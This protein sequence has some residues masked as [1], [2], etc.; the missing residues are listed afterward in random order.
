MP[1]TFVG[2]LSFLAF[3]TPGLIHH[4]Q[5]RR[6]V[7]EASTSQLVET[8]TLVTVSLATNLLTLGLF[9]LI[10]I[11][12][13][14]HSP[15][16]RRLLTE[17]NGYIGSRAGY[18]LLWSVAFVVVSS[19]F[20]SLLGLFGDKLTGRL[21]RAVEFLAPSI[22]NTSA[23]YKVFE[24]CPTDARVYVGC[25]LRDGMYLGGYLAWYSTEV[26][27]TADRDLILGGGLTVKKGGKVE[28]SE[29]DRVVI[30]AREVERIY[31]TYVTRA[32]G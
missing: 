24:D 18:I 25:D 2:L 28:T 12:A 14:S 31:V 3:L 20:A 7:P 19:L 17:G 5:R 6:H 8:A 30:S 11:A 22:V 23:W 10:R 32:P 13:A 9:S 1:S 29:F 4:V 21:G 15:D 27:E 16:P 26:S